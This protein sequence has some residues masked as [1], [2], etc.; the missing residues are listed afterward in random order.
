ME[1]KLG[2]S[3]NN[4]F[5]EH[6]RTCASACCGPN[7]NVALSNAERDFLRSAGT[8]LFLIAPA[9]GDNAGRNLYSLESKC[10]FVIFED[11]QYKCKIFG[12]PQRPAICGEFKAGSKICSQIKETRRQGVGYV[13]GY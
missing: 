2:R 10:G 12:N 4:G 3:V 6:C 5:N 13:F 8:N 9:A 11:N 7:I 1:E